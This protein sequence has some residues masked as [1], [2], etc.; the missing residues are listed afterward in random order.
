MGQVWNDREPIYRQL[1]ARVIDALLDGELKEGDSIP[2][3]RQTAA[4]FSVNP[5]TVTKAYE[6]LASEGLVEK[7]RG[8][9]LF[10]RPGARAHLLTVERRRLLDEEW[11]VFAAR[12]RRLGVALSD[13]PFPSSSKEK[14]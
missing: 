11:P 8:L 6:D 7:R 10:V 4:E 2:S 12:L 13:L 9:G 5:I 3:V 14:P 1:R